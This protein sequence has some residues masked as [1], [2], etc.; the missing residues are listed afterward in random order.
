MTMRKMKLVSFS[1]RIASS[2]MKF[3]FAKTKSICVEEERSMLPIFIY[4]FRD[5]I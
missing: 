3:Y 1:I 5:Y 4:L 2:G